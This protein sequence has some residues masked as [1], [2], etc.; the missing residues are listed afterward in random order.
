MPVP[1]RAS[2]AIGHPSN[3]KPTSPRQALSA[4]SWRSS[5]VADRS[6]IRSTTRAA[7][8]DAFAALF[9]ADSLR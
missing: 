7:I 1:D 5:S 6:L 9:G 3:D 8:S 2:G 4:A